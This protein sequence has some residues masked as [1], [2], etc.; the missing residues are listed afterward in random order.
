M[1]EIVKES[2]NYYPDRSYKNSAKNGTI[3]TTF[4]SKENEERDSGVSTKT[5]RPSKKKK[6]GKSYVNALFSTRW[7]SKGIEIVLTLPPLK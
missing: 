7:T 4:R 5:I 2:E 6:K 1:Q 3:K